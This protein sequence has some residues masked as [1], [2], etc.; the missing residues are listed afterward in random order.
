[1]HEY[2]QLF[3]MFDT[4]NSGAIGNEELKQAILNFGHQA[5]DA[6]ID[7]LIQEAFLK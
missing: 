3:D 2:R 6:E 4:D 7:Q 1:M 5:T